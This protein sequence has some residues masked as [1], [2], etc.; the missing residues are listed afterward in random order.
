MT[1]LAGSNPGVLHFLCNIKKKY[2]DKGYSDI[3][4]EVIL[5]TL[6]KNNIHGNKIWMLYKDVCKEKEDNLYTIMNALLLGFVTKDQVTFAIDNREQGIDLSAIKQA[7]SQT[8][9]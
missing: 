1:E 3:Y 8:M 9:N 5:S 4:F 7:V 2:D 6:K